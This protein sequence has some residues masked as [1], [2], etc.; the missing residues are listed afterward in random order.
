MG[1]GTDSTAGTA[2]PCP[3]QTHGLEASRLLLLL[4][5][6]PHHG[7]RVQL[8]IAVTIAIAIVLLGSREGRQRRCRD[9]G[10]AE[11]KG[12]Q[13]WGHRYWALTLEALALGTASCEDYGTR[14]LRTLV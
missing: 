1:R 13:C 2:A 14:G 5:L 4:V 12:H 3:A 9:L 10:T 6:R 11:G 7:P 8:G